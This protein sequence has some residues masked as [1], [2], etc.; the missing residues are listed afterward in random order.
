[1]ASTQRGTHG[2][3]RGVGAGTQLTVKSVKG[4]AVNTA[5]V[6]TVVSSYEYGNESK[7]D[8]IPGNDGP[9][10]ELA[11]WDYRDTIR[12][13]AMCAITPAASS[14]AAVKALWLNLPVYLD[15]VEIASTDDTQIV[16]DSSGV[17]KWFVKSATKRGV[18]DGYATATFELFR[19]ES[20]LVAVT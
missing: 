1:M 13:E 20:D 12:V 5:N 6:W 17:D 18:R 2:A 16:G 19:T 15:G 8:E 10:I 4:V 3:L 11:G 14:I 9:P 7:S